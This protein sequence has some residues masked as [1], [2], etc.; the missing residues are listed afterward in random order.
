MPST[1]ISFTPTPVALVTSTS[2]STPV[3]SR[4]AQRVLTATPAECVRK[5]MMEGQV[6]ASPRRVANRT[7][8]AA[9]SGSNSTLR[10]PVKAVSSSTPV[11]ITPLMKTP[12]KATR[13]V[14]EK[15]VL[16]D[17]PVKVMRASRVTIDTPVA[18]KVSVG[19]IMG[20]EMVRMRAVEVR[21]CFSPLSVPR[22]DDDVKDS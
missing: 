7:P 10:S 13:V 14:V 5:V 18:K 21:F 22:Y 16:G 19:S 17:S 8:T 1:P 15:V 12:T 2:Q 4:K 20:G 9:A 3:S 6:V 11:A